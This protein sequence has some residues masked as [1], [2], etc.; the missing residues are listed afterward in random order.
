MKIEIS[1]ELEGEIF[2]KM[3]QQILEY[4]ETLPSILKE[5]Y[6]G[7]KIVGIID[8]KDMGGY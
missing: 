8:I 2:E 5:N 6:D 7:F 1:I 3:E 4:V